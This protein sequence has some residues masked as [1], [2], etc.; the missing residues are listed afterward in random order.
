M[1]KRF[2]N[3]RIATKLFLIL[4]VPLAGLLYISIDG[5]VRQAVIA[6]DTRR[7][8]T[9]ISFSTQ[10]GATVHE[11]QK[12]RGTSVL[13]LSSRSDQ[14]KSE[15]LAQRAVSDS[16]IAKFQVALQNIDA[17]A[18]G[19]AFQANIKNVTT[20]LETI[21]EKRKQIDAFNITADESSAFYTET[22]DALLTVVSQSTA[23]NNAELA[24]YS[25]AYLALLQAKERAGRERANLSAALNVG[26]FSADEFHKFLTISNEQDTYFKLFLFYASDEER[27]FYRDTMTGPLVDEATNIEQ[28]ALKAT[29]DVKLNVDAQRWFDVATGRINLL[30]EV[31]NKMADDLLKS[32]SGARQAAVRALWFFIATAVVA[33]A[34]VAVSIF[35]ARSISGALQSMTN[36]AQ[37]VAGGDL[38]QHIA[39]DTQDE[40][41][42]LAGAFNDMTAQLRRTLEDVNRRAVELATVA[43]VGTATA[44]ILETDK[45]L[46]EVVDLSKERF[47]LYH[48]HIFLLDEK[49]ENLV[50]A[51]GAGE[52]GAQMKAKGL[53]IP[54]NREQS[55]VARAA[56]DRKG[57]TVNDVTQAPDFLANP[58]LPNTRS[59]L[60]VPMVVGD[61]VIGVFDVQSDV[62]G[63]FTDSDINIQ[64]TLASQVATSIQNVRSFEQSKE[65]ADLEA[66]VNA[67]NQ[68]IQRSDSIN[69][70]L[71][72]AARELGLALGSPRVSVQIQ[73]A[74]KAT[75]AAKMGA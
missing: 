51:S 32:A 34:F 26:Q 7:F 40:I 45:L 56:R 15:M 74:A 64:T 75:D 68:K 35:F 4:L 22:I 38:N 50:L 59:E 3:L 20:A 52:A 62:V 58:L 67:I 49:G 72:I 21:A 61:K 46:Q 55:L 60:A 57:V 71:Q 27:A 44:T 19:D 17:N 29:S 14:A 30:K 12:E 42:V 24:R 69:D 70:A 10:I 41:G 43:E 13:F 36:T 66:M 54:L 33:V 6:A 63:R 39:V 8:E 73:S 47:N 28:G 9:L 37:Q 16:E 23:L 65:Q 1:I 53:S 5:V 18:Y 31:E 2:N 25:S 11:I 48:S